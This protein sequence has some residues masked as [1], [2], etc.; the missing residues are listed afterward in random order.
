MYANRYTDTHTLTH[1]HRHTNTRKL[2][3][4]SSD[5]DFLRPSATRPV[6]QCL[7]QAYN[8]HE[9]SSPDNAISVNICPI[10]AANKSFITST[11]CTVEK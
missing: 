8:R 2:S 5:S 10:D 11:V 7:K 4:P 1:T 3:I 6:S 9:G